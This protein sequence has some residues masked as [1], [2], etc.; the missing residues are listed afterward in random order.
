V[1]TWFQVFAFSNSNL[2]RYTP[3]EAREA[4]EDEEERS[5]EDEKSAGR[6]MERNASSSSLTRM[7]DGSDYSSGE[8]VDENGTPLPF[9]AA[10]A[11][12]PNFHRPGSPERTGVRSEV[13]ASPRASDSTRVA[14]ISPWPWW[15]VMLGC[16]GCGGAVQAESS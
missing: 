10:A 16:D 3:A 6:D 13:P 7:T 2:Y 9:G 12:P 5:A 15:M 14:P 8:D 4:D 1:K 11:S